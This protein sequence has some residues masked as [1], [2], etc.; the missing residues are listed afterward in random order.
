MVRH[1]PNI[2]CDPF[3]TQSLDSA[4]NCGYNSWAL[5]I[6]KDFCEQ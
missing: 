1:L 5:P 6:A 4:L 2:T 3:L